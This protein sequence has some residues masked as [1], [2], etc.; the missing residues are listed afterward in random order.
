MWGRPEPAYEQ[1]IWQPTLNTC[2]IKHCKP[3]LAARR[4]PRLTFDCKLAQW[5]TFLSEHGPRRWLRRP[6]CAPAA[7]LARQRTHTHRTVHTPLLGVDTRRRCTPPPPLFSPPRGWLGDGQSMARPH[8]PSHESERG[9]CWASESLCVSHWP[10]SQVRHVGH[11][12]PVWWIPTWP[13]V[14]PPLVCYPGDRSCRND[15]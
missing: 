8:T 11:R 9:P 15:L 13:S 1:M 12:A 5:H 14:L 6:R 10:Q 7:L 2:L 3:Q 4:S